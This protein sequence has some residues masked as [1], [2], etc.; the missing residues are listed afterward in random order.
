MYKQSPFTPPLT[1]KYI[2]LVPKIVRK[3]CQIS[4]LISFSLLNPPNLKRKLKRNQPD[5][6]TLVSS[7]VFRKTEPMIRN[8][9]VQLVVFTIRNQRNQQRACFSGIS[10]PH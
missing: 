2:V 3:T 4:H 8:S 10:L 6:E 9:L 1:K 5:L 7:W